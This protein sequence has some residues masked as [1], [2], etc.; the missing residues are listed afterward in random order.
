IAGFSSGFCW[1]RRHGH[2]QRMDHPLLP[3]PPMPS[4]R[5]PARRLT[6]VGISLALVLVA[7]PVRA[8]E[9]QPPSALSLDAA[10]RAAFA[11]NRDVI[12]ARLGVSAAEVERVAAGVLPNPQFGYGVGNFAIGGGTLNCIN[13]P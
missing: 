4:I 7:Q 12:A 11:R 6:A 9:P 8:A 2:G 10:I 5:P 1:F 3:V 13:V